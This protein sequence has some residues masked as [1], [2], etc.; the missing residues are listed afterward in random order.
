M[1]KKKSNALTLN[2]L[3]FMTSEWILKN[4]PFVLFLGFLATIYI[5]NAHYAERNVRDIQV[6]Q[7]DLKEL[8]WYYMSLQSENMYN[9][10]RSEVVE[11]VKDEGIRPLRSKPKKII[12]E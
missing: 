6:I 11:S 3:S 4:V 2:D 12:V 5:A 10:K 7:K 8:R 9:S 1:A